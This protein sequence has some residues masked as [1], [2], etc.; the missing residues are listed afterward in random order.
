MLLRRIK[1]AHP[2]VYTF[3][4][5][6]QNVTVDSLFDL[7]RLNSGLPIRRPKK[8]CYV[9]NDK[10]IKTSTGRLLAGTINR[11]EFLRAVA[12][13]IHPRILDESERNSEN[14]DSSDND[15]NDGYQVSNN[16]NND[17]TAATQS[18]A[19]SVSDPMGNQDIDVAASNQCEVCLIQPR[20]RQA[21]VP[22]GHSRLCDSCVGEIMRLTSACPVCRTSIAMVINIF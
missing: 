11:L 2:N 3:L 18:V 5:H 10:R 20:S 12:H 1:S 14:D 15:E 16:N 13:N 7:T 6:I 4:G 22:C 17:T 8:K 21:F 19:G 9:A